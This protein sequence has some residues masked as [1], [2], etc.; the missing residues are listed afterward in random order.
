MCLVLLVHTFHIR[1]WTFGSIKCL[2]YVRVCLYLCLCGSPLLLLT[3]SQGGLSL[4]LCVC[5][6]VLLMSCLCCLVLSCLCVLSI[7]DL[8]RYQCHVYVCVCL[9]GWFS[10]ASINFFSR[11]PLA[12]VLFCLAYAQVLS[13]SDIERLVL[14]MSYLCA[15][16]C[17]CGSPLLLLTSSQDGHLP[18]SLHRPIFSPRQLIVSTPRHI[19]AAAKGW[20][21]TRMQKQKILSTPRHIRATATTQKP[22]PLKTA[23]KNI[24]FLLWCMLSAQYRIGGRTH[25][26][27]CSGIRQSQ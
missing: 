26:L 8:E 3:S 13:I 16:L 25:L 1:S 4:V 20:F 2:V 27:L 12:S 23:H 10:I 5:S 21:Q 9:C 15:C 6:L 18:Q 7:S 19:R 14:S 17:V 11:R 22:P 24:H